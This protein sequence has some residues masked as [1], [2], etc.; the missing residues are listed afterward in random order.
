MPQAIQIETQA[1]QQGLAHLHRQAAGWGAGR[2][3]AFEQKK[4]VLDR[5]ATPVQLLRKSPPHLSTHSAR[6]PSF[7]STLG[8]DDTLHPELMTNVGVITLAVEFSIGQHQSD[9]SLLE[10][11]FDHRGQFRAVVP[12][13]ASCSLRQQEPLVQVRHNNFQKPVTLNSHGCGED[14]NRAAW[15]LAD[16]IH[17]E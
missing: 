13:A 15:H 8:G 1:E 6:A 7:L 11:S 12:E 4:N 2:E 9:V 3:L 16:I 17:E 14:F 10:S 5:G